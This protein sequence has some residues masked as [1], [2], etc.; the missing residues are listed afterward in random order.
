MYI[1]SIFFNSDQYHDALKL[2]GILW[3]SEKYIGSSAEF[4]YMIGKLL[5]Y[6]HDNILN[7]V[8][9]FRR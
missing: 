8:D 7:R 4:H 9:F 5:G 3:Y 6:Y 2:M 1:K